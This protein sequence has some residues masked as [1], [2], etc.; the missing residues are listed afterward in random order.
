MSEVQALLGLLSYYR[1]FVVNFSAIASPLNSLLS[2]GVEF[3]WGSEQQSALDELKRVLTTEG[4]ALKRVDPNQPLILYC[5]WSK[6]GIGAVL[7]QVGTDGQEYICV[8]ISRSLNKHERQYVS[9]KGELLACVWACQILRKYLWGR[10]FTVIT[11]HQPLQWLMANKDLTGQYARWAMIMS[12]YEFTIVHRKGSEHNNADVLSR[13]PRADSTD[14]SGA[15]LDI[16]STPAPLSCLSTLLCDSPLQLVSVDDSAWGT[17]LSAAAFLTTTGRQFADC[18]LLCNA[19]Q[20]RASWHASVFAASVAA[21]PCSVLSDCV[22]MGDGV[23]ETGCFAD[24]SE[25]VLV[26]TPLGEQRIQQLRANAALWHSTVAPTL[27]ELSTNPDHYGPWRPACIFNKSNSKETTV[28]ADRFGVKSTGAVCTQVIGPSFFVNTCTDGVVLLELFGGICTGLEMVLRS[29]VCVLQYIYCDIDPVAQRVAAHRMH[30]LSAQYP[31]LFPIE[32]FVSAFT[33]VP[34]DVWQIN[35]AALLH[36][37]VQDGRQWLVVAGWE[38]SDLSPAGQGAGLRG[39]HS[40]TFFA[41]RQIL[42]AIQQLQQ[43]KPP[44]YLLEN[45]YLDFDFGKVARDMPN[46]RELIFSSVGYPVSCDAARFG[47]YAHR[48]RHFWTNLAAAEH[49]QCCIESVVRPPGLTVLDILLPGRSVL[50]VEVSDRKPFYPCN[51]KLGV[52]AAW[53]TFVTVVNSRAFRPNGPGAVIDCALRGY[54]EPCPDERELAL[55]FDVGCTRVP[56]YP[57]QPS[58]TETHRHVLTGRAMDINAVGALFA[59][60]LRLAQPGSAALAN[61]PFASAV[62]VAPTVIG[63]LPQPVLVADPVPGFS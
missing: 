13:M 39:K 47:S 17:P 6:Q 22:P 1:R 16:D 14:V 57:R 43:Q 29:G 21:D 31:A 8:C 32:A 3:V 15:R 18:V 33:A 27:S 23:C 26:N 48:L 40:N 63:F 41:L 52:R 20:G 37:G 11:D 25:P 46:D 61:S 7:A 51:V 24:V 42:G 44:G 35:T 55:G 50:P 19:A 10:A 38:C 53:P 9:Y 2:K 28:K 36:A 4:L 60:C 5:D 12:D 34:Q 54:T 45:T 49:L 58:V 59:L 30:H 62:S 56:D